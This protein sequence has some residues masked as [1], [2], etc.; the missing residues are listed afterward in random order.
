M[1]AGSDEGEIVGI[2]VSDVRSVAEFAVK[3]VADFRK[4]CDAGNV[5]F[6]PAKMDSPVGERRE[7]FANSRT[8][9]TPR[10]TEK[11]TANIRP[12]FAFLLFG[13]ETRKLPF[14][15]HNLKL[16]VVVRLPDDSGD[17]IEFLVLKIQECRAP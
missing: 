9:N 2:E 13:D 3:H 1:H 12:D 7:I 14:R 17:G 11:P 10:S 8:L 5:P 15:K 6:L 16:Q 4:V